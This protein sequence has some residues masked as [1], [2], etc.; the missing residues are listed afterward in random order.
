MTPIRL[1]DFLPYRL[2]VLSQRLS[3]EL[4]A[5]YEHQHGLSAPQWRVMA[6]VAE[7][8]GRTAQEV[9]RMTPM[10]KATVSRAVS[11][12][13]ERGLM[14][15]E[16]DDRDGRSSRLALTESGKSLY[17][18]IAPAVLRVEASIVSAMAACSKSELLMAVGEIE[19]SLET[20]DRLPQAAE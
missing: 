5:V 6:A 4:A 9:V 11:A 16:A 20:T 19:A 14:R 3:A 7:R 2:A 15:R 13:I 17:A 18:L 12:M 10:E 1:H 8:P